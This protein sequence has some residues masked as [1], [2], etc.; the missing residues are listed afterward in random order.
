M[1]V[2]IN[3][4]STFFIIFAHEIRQL[5]RMASKPTTNREHLIVIITISKKH[6]QDA[7]TRCT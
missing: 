4:V 6:Q 2:K 7:G 1:R 5:L 3:N